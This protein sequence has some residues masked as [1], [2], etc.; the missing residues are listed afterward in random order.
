MAKQS[1]IPAKV[2]IDDSSGVL[3]DITNDITDF[4]LSTP[5]GVQD[6]TG[7]DKL[8]IERL[9]L[10]A[11]GQVT[12]NGVFNKE[13][14]KSH[15]VFKTVP[16]SSVERTVTIDMGTT[17]GDPRLSMEMLFTEYAINRAP[18]GELTWSATGQLSDGTAPTWST[19]P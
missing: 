1:G 7:L 10:L 8:G 14:N 19:V 18:T 15:D 2:Q 9:L 17:A 12:I 4:S 13:S 16:S 5:R 3:Q 6:I 11:D